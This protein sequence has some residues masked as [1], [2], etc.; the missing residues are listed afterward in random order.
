MRL[1]FERYFSYHGASC[2]DDNEEKI[3]KDSP[4]DGRSS[5]AN[6]CSF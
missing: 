4:D 3:V 2:W 5:P 1:R 6:D